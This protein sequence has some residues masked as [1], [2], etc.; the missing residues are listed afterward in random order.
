[1]SYKHLDQNERL[2]IYTWLRDWLSQREIWARLK[3]SPATISRELRRNKPSKNAYDPLFAERRRLRSLT[4]RRLWWSKIRTDTELER[5]I[6]YK[7]TIN[8][9]SPDN[10]AGR[11]KKETWRNISTQT[12]YNYIYTLRPELKQ[13]LKYK[14]WYRKR[15][16]KETRGSVNPGRSIDERPVSVYNRRRFGHWE[17]DTVWSKRPQK[18]WL[19][20][21]VERK[22]RYC[23][24]GRL[25][26]RKSEEVRKQTCELL[27]RYEKKKLLTITRDNG[28]EFSQYAAVE[29]ELGIKYYSAH[30]YASHERG[31]N[32]HTNGMIRVFYP[33]WTDFSEVSEQ[34][35]WLLKQR[36]NNKPRK[37]LKYKTPYEVLFWKSLSYF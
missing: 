28:K 22:S 4:Q 12:I 26:S 19:L 23:E 10:I 6:V 16:M 15:W 35:I 24:V 8:R 11:L 37:I 5:V 9:R 7:L 2:L 27:W 21:I 30:T 1:M 29:E 17:I 14:K 25:E 33:K 18:W 13:Y 34:E 31:T 20:T 36:T 3:R 32:E